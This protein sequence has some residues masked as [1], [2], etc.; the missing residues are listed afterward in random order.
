MS[1]LKISGAMID[2]SISTKR[3]L[4]NFH[5]TVWG[6]YFLSYTPQ[7][8]V[9]SSF[10]KFSQSQ[11]QEIST[12]EKLELEE[13]KEKVRKMLV[14]TPDNSTQKTCLDRR[15]QRL[16]VAY[17][18]KNEIK[19][20]IQN[21]FDE[22]EESNND[23]DLYVVALRFR[24]VRQQRHYMSSAQLRVHGEEILEEALSF[25]ITHLESMIPILSNLLKDQVRE[26]LSESIHTNLPR[27]TARKYIC[28]YENINSH[29]KLLLRFAKLD[30]NIVQKVH[31]KELGELTRW[32]KDLDF[33]EK[34]SYARDR[35]VECHFYSVGVYFEPEYSRAREL[36]TKV[37]A[38]YTIIDDT[39]DAYAT[40]D[41]LVPF[42]AAIDRCDIS[43]MDSVP[44]SLRHTYQALIDIY[45]QI[46]EKL[47]KEGTLD[48]LYYTKYEMKKLARDFFKEAQWLNAGHIPKCEEYMKNANVTTTCMMVATTSL[49]FMEETIAKEIFE[50]KSEDQ[51]SI[52]EPH[53]QIKLGIKIIVGQLQNPRIKTLL[54]D[55]Q[56]RE[57][58][59][60]SIKA[61]RNPLSTS[62]H[63]IDETKINP[64]QRETKKQTDRA[65]GSSGDGETAATPVLRWRRRFAGRVSYSCWRQQIYRGERREIGIEG[66]GGGRTVSDGQ[67]FRRRM[68]V[69][70]GRTGARASRRA[71][72]GAAT[73]GGGGRSG[74]I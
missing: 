74:R 56:N 36:L 58:R 21:I 43:A 32:W 44:H 11:S 70:R 53:E 25:T 2:S 73:A 14:E 54:Y 30:F 17:H 60:D 49:S 15:N 68:K 13:L 19:T 31:Q 7:L 8:T 65:P 29:N 67:L 72:V 57:R 3:P 62:K 63:E 71:V 51:N 4:A 38:I 5:P 41:E 40:Y 37:L 33:S 22:S 64:R 61:T 24:L 10:D 18:F 27:M 28:I 39:Y 20:S 48:H 12:Q 16:G 69:L 34:F 66:D 50:W 6:N 47:T 1:K 42:T 45:T 59:R 35:L 52:R 9:R 46:E 23:D 26:A 55:T